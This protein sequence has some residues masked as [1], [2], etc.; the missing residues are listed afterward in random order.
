LRSIVVLTTRLDLF[1]RPTARRYSQQ[2]NTQAPS[3]GGQAALELPERQ[4]LDVHQ[5]R[6]FF[7]L[8]ANRPNIHCRLVLLRP[9]CFL[10]SAV[11]E[12]L[13]CRL[14]V[15]ARNM[16]ILA[17]NARSC[18]RIVPLRD[19]YTLLP[20]VSRKL[21]ERVRMHPSPLRLMLAVFS[22]DQSSN[23]TLQLVETRQRTVQPR[24]RETE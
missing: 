4:R 3:R 24:H 11:S 2:R 1:R 14:S 23:E 8:L 13:P 7:I 17:C 18:A 6:L 19:N 12:A 9:N 21:R 16:L 5:R 15:I 20:R 10:S 22:S